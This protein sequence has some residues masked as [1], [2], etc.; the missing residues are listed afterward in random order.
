MILKNIKIYASLAL[1]CL[2]VSCK[3]GCLDPIA[4][5]YNPN[6]KKSND[7]LCQYDAS[8]NPLNLEVF[9]L[10][11]GNNFS[12]DSIYYDD[13]GTMV[14]FNRAKTYVSKN[15]FFK[16]SNSCFD[17]TLQYLLFD[18]SISNYF[19]G[20]I[21]KEL[22]TI[23]I[24]FQVGVDSVSNHSDPASYQSEEPL[25]Y[26]TPSMHWQMGSNLMDWSYL[27][28]V[29]EGFADLNSNGI[30]DAGEIFVFHLG[31]DDFR[32]N[33]KNI[34]CDI[35]EFTNESKIKINLNWSK[36]IED[37]D[38][39]NENF[40]HTIDNI[41]LATKIATNSNNFISQYQ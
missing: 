32:S 21:E 4:T 27:F 16:S 37:I 29:V 40:T 34:S 33:P 20:Y 13:F 9:H 35:S 10:F 12:L 5:N 3:E 26:Q 14:K 23:S 25:S 31:G 28:V 18:P 17:D 24:E 11:N 2:L 7:E 8:K 15:C 19:L 6:A 1:L 22:N 39:K 30:F 41:P 36:I 38:I